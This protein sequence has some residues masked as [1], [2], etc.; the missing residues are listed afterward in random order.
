MRIFAS[1]LRLGRWCNGNT[2]DSGPVIQGSS[3]CR[4]TNFK[5]PFIG[6]FFVLCF[7]QYIKK[8]FSRNEVTPKSFLSDFWGS[9]HR[10]GFFLYV[11]SSISLLP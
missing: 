11:S 7:G 4:P 5:P 1:Q 10:I 6:G 2:T 8:E 3:P 9:L